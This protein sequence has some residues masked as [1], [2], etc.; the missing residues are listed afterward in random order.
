MVAHACCYN[1]D[2]DSYP[3]ADEGDH[4]GDDGD[5]K[6]EGPAPKPYKPDEP[7]GYK[8]RPIEYPQQKP[9]FGGYATQQNT[10]AGATPTPP[11][12]AATPAAA[13]PAMPT[14]TFNI[15]GQQPGAAMRAPHLIG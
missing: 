11:A 2:E 6:P 10:A 14:P 12:A 7:K 9:D 8:P 13:A 1:P 3:D 15:G 4:G 5:D